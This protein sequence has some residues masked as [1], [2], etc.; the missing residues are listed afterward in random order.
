[1]IHASDADAL[2]A[3]FAE[4]FALPLAFPMAEHPGAGASGGVF[5]GNVLLEVLRWAVRLPWDLP[6]SSAR[7]AG[8]AL[9]AAGPVETTVALLDTRGIAHT[10]PY[11]P[12]P[13]YTNVRLPEFMA[14]HLV[15]LTHVAPEILE[16]RRLRRQQLLERDGG[17]LGIEGVTELVIAVS[18]GAD[19]SDRW[20]PLLAPKPVTIPGCVPLEHGPAIRFTTGGEDRLVGI[21]F[22]VTDLNRATAFLDQQGLLGSRGEERVSIAPEQVQQLQLAFTAT[23]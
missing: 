1:M 13:T 5:A 20:G 6:A 17:P 12:V 11:T 3:L 2:L 18:D 19:A 4:T 10:A 7:I 8:L 23:T 15:F 21:V 9:H 22:R 16:S 14:N